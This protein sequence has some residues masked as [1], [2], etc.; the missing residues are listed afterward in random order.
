M[1]DCLAQVALDP[2]VGDEGLCVGAPGRVLDED[3]ADKVGPEEGE[4]RGGGGGEGDVVVVDD[5]RDG[6]GLILDLK[7]WPEQCEDI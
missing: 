5:A 4:A 7:R 1:G 2:W 6:L 3:G